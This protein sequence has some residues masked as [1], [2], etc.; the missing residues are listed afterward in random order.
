MKIYENKNFNKP[1]SL[2]KLFDQ[3]PP[4]ERLVKA[5]AKKYGQTEDEVWRQYV[6]CVQGA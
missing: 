5:V 1:V 4:I 2:K 6:D 3:N